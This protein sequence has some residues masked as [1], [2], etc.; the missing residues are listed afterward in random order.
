MLCHRDALGPD[1]PCDGI[2]SH[3]E[4]IVATRGLKEIARKISQLS[5]GNLAFFSAHKI[6]VSHFKN[7]SL[8]VPH[9]RTPVIKREHTAYAYI[10]HIQKKSTL[11][12]TEL[13]SNGFDHS[14]SQMAC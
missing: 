5:Y 3:Q 9:W 1:R 2:R 8:L 4:I 11:T 10:N 12:Q 7:I 14:S 6:I 13:S